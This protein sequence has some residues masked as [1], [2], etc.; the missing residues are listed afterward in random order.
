M[1]VQNKKNSNHKIEI[2]FLYGKL[3]FTQM[4]KE[5]YQ[6]CCQLNDFSIYMQN[7]KPP[8]ER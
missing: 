2:Y 5:K 8:N 3:E 1:K 6:I 7:F 4:A